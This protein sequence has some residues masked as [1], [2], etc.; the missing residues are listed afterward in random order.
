MGQIRSMTGYGTGEVLCGPR[1]VV[2]EVTLLADG[3]ATVKGVVVAVQMPKAFLG[4]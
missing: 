1:K 3:V 4:G 2:V